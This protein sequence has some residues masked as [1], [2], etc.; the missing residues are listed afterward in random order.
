[1]SQKGKTYAELG[2]SISR[3]P[4]TGGIQRSR[5]DSGGFAPTGAPYHTQPRTAAP[6]SRGY[7]E[8]LNDSPD[9]TPVPDYGSVIRNAVRG[10]SRER[11][12]RL[13]DYFF[14]NDGLVG[15]AVTTI[16]NYSVPITPQAAG[17]DAEVNRAYD[18]Y[19]SQWS[20]RA[21]YTGRFDLDTIQRV[22][23]IGLDTKGEAAAIL[24]EENGIP[25]LQLIPVCRITD[26]Y[27]E[28]P[29]PHSIDGVKH[30][31][32]GVIVGY[33]VYGDDGNTQLI[34]SDCMVLIYDPERS[35]DYRGI[36][37]MRRGLN[38]VRDA[39]DIKGFE[40]LATKISSAGRIR[41]SLEQEAD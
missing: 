26:R 28:T 14:D 24:T 18:S 21:D 25:Q 13:G 12:A 40:K 3:I 30:N 11:L 39:K 2:L 27:L 38:D 9:R 6:T 37:P 32:K 23:C 31:G 22:A 17:S 29:D 7:Y 16:A 5:M 15:Y 35:E 33:Y 34:S 4:V 19:F 20:R 10:Y 36:S 41:L 8:A 1:M